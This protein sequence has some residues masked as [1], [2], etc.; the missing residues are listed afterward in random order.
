MDW[1]ALL[2]KVNCYKREQSTALQLMHSSGHYKLGH[3]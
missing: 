2:A 3:A 1:N